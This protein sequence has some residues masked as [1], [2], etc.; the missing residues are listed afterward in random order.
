MNGWRERSDRD[1]ALPDVSYQQERP[2][3]G[4][5]I[6]GLAIGAVIMGGAWYFVGNRPTLSP[7]LAM[8]SLKSWIDDTAKQLEQRHGKGGAS[9][10]DALRGEAEAYLKRLKALRREMSL[11]EIRRRSAEVKASKVIEQP[12]P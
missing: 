9:G 6:A 3:P 7:E 4:L 2:S 1:Y 5:F 8:A 10:E 11:I 12:K